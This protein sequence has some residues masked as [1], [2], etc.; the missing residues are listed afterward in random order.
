MRELSRRA[1]FAG[2]LLVSPALAYA[3]ATLTGV[4]RDPSGAVLSGV[5]VEAWCPTLI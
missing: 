2:I 3:Q 5:S 1:I 4:V